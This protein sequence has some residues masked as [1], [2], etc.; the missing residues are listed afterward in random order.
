MYEDAEEINKIINRLA[1]EGKDVILVCNSY[2]G[3]PSTEGTKGTSRAERMSCGRSGG[4]IGIVYLSAFVARIGQCV[5]DIMGARMPEQ[6]VSSNGYMSMDPEAAVNFIFAHLGPEDR[7]LYGRRFRNHCARTFSDGLTYP[8]YMK[9]PSTYVLCSDDPVIPPE[10][11]NEMIKSA[12]AQD[13]EMVVQEI[14]SDHCPMVTHPEE[15][16]KILIAVAEGDGK[17]TNKTQIDRFN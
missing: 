2:G 10:L 4:L 13:A 14:Y 17:Y 7:T 9:V 6:E 15:V 1:D 11:Q 8:G 5:R 16:A 12:L 3:I